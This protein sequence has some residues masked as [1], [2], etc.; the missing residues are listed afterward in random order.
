[1]YGN[2]LPTGIRKSMMRTRQK[3]AAFRKILAADARTEAT[4]LVN[5]TSE[6]HARC[7]K[8]AP[9]SA[10][11]T[12]VAAIVPLHVMPNRST[13]QQAMSASGAS[14]GRGSHHEQRQDSRE[15]AKLARLRPVEG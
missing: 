14:P 8:A 10:L 2:G 7:L 6:F 12:I 15:G 4:T 1:M 13:P 5:R 11:L 3:R 9:I